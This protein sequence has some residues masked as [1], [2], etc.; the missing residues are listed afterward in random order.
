MGGVCQP[1]RSLDVRLLQLVEGLA[2]RRLD[3]DV[4]L[5]V[6]LERLAGEPDE[7][8][9]ERSSGSALH[10][11]LRRRLEDDDLAALRAGDV[12]ADPAGEHAVA[13]AGLASGGGPG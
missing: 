2:V 6:L 10:E 11:R 5:V 9:D 8:L 3:E 1:P 7:A 12:E 13:E 4:A